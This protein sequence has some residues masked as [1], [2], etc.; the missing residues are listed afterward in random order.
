MEPI[1][2]TENNPIFTVYQLNN[3]ARGILEQTFQ[4]VWVKGELSN[5]ALPRS[6]HIY[7]TLKD[8]HAQ[9]RCA[10]FKGN[11]KRLNFVPKDGMEV[12][13]RANVSIYEERGDYQLIVSHMEQ[14]GLGQLQQAFEALKAKLHKEGLFDNQ[15]KK[16]PPA[17]PTHIAVITSQTGAA[18]QDILSVLKRRYPIAPVT[19]LHTQVQGKSAAHEIVQAI[20]YAN[21]HPEFDVVL[22]ARGGGSLEDLWSFNEEIVARAIHASQLPIITGIGHE[23]DFT[24]ADFVAD[25]RAP[26]PSAAAESITPDTIEVIQLFEQQYGRLVHAMQRHL[27]HAALKVD[28]LEKQLVHPGQ[29]LQH[30]ASTCE[31]LAHRLLLAMQQCLQRSEKKLTYLAG[32]LHTVSPLATLSRGYAITTLEQT[33]EIVRDASQLRPGQIL[34]TRVEK[35]EFLSTVN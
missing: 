20:Q 29:K 24:I 30:M 3:Y 25:Y 8:A 17:F 16:A 15:W 33:G 23:V 27:Q 32:N 26:T 6:G 7:F 4:Q 19:I 2:N 5:V 34:K 28:S 22:L 1:E 35:G 21:T 18:L 13:L 9:I 14:G 10:L 11:H 31:N 12:L